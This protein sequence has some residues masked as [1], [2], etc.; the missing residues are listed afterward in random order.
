MF[1]TF[2]NETICCFCGKSL[3]SPK[4]EKIKL[5]HWSHVSTSRAPLHPGNLRLHLLQGRSGGHCLHI[6]KPS[7]RKPPQTSSP[8]P[9]ATKS[10]AHPRF[11]LRT[12]WIMNIKQHISLWTTKSSWREGLAIPTPRGGLAA[13][14]LPLHTTPRSQAGHTQ[15]RPC[16]GASSSCLR[17]PWVTTQKTQKTSLCA[18]SSHACRVKKQSLF[19]NAGKLW[20][21]FAPS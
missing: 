2:H 11:P 4:K 16:L 7:Y 21:L 19:P 18:S 14:Q 13:A 20:N 12:T 1:E 15:P 5:K 17:S 9:S 10:S 8:H 6:T 3:A